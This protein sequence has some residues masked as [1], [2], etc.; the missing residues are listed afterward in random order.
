MRY[1][2]LNDPFLYGQWQ[3]HEKEVIG[4]THHPHRN[5]V[6]TYS[7]DSTMKLWKP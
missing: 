6:A 2:H 1:I 7:E 4:A 5:L 3:V